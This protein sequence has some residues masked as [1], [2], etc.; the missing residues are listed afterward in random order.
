ML[1]PRTRLDPE[2]FYTVLG[3]DPAANPAAIR[4]AFRRK[5]R[6]VHPDVP[7]TGDA[8]AFVAVKRAYDVLSNG[9]RR[10]SY[11]QA[12][13]QAVASG[14]S[15]YT[16]WHPPP[17][18][19]P[20]EHDGSAVNVDCRSA[21]QTI[22][23]YLRRPDFSRWRDLPASAIAVWVALGAFLGLC[24]FEAG[25][26]LR[27]SP[28]VVNAGIRPNAAPVTP[29]SPSAQRTELYG[30]DPVR[31]AGT[32]RLLRKSGGRCHGALAQGHRLGRLCSIRPI[33]AVQRGPGGPS[34]PSEWSDRSADKRHPDRFR[35]LQ[36][37]DPRRR[38]HCSPSLLRIQR[39]VRSL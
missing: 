9:K 10:E 26:H 24:I 12:A 21:Y 13:R 37:T 38:R 14:P 7:G 23:G 20:A 5:A 17:P 16:A 11:D 3:L 27:A 15:L 29:L 35:R 4:A 30:P 33:A 18:R 28:P 39:R 22:R 8:G 2:G 32:P 34:A 1:P 36:A 6:E 25:L 31:L 19:Q